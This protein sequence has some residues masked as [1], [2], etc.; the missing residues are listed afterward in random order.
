MRGFKQRVGD[1]RPWSFLNFP[2]QITFE[3]YHEFYQEGKN[4][5]EFTHIAEA[6][7]CIYKNHKSVLSS[8][9]LRGNLCNRTYKG[10]FNKS[11]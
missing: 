3:I 7:H 1:A 11:E 9:I 6:I 8:L 5:E 10:R 2:Y 4:R